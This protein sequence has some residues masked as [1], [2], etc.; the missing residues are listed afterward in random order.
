[1]D[2]PN[3]QVLKF[4]SSNAGPVGALLLGLLL[5][6]ILWSAVALPDRRTIWL[7]VAAVSVVF[8]AL[9]RIDVFE[10]DKG[11][12]RFV[13]RSIRMF[14]NRHRQF[15]LREIERVN[16]KHRTFNVGY[17]SHSNPYAFQLTVALT[18]GAEVTLTGWQS[19]LN[20]QSQGFALAEFL[21]VPFDTMA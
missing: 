11:A 21:G 18:S 6:A 10:L 4:R 15:R 3:S 17:R 5:P 19:S 8:L 1:M 2:Q 13:L 16:I 9:I 12:D 7:C 14:G 20:V